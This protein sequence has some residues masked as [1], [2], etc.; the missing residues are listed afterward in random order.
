[1]FYFQ[2]VGVV[3]LDSPTTFVLRKPTVYGLS[4]QAP[5]KARAGPQ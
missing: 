3:G 1:M 4:Y 5:P 2:F